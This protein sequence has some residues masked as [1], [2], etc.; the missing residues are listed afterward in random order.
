MNNSLLLFALNKKLGCLRPDVDAVLRSKTCGSTRRRLGP[1]H[2]TAPPP[3]P[4]TLLHHYH[5]HHQ[6]RRAPASCSVTCSST[7]PELKSFF[8]YAGPAP[9]NRKPRPFLKSVAPPPQ[10]SVQTGLSCLRPSPRALNASPAQS[11]RVP[12]KNVGDFSY[13]VLKRWRV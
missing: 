8:K 12:T 5:H 1:A 6:Q 11:R 9:F 4:V 13:K 2:S 7:T 3:P 10:T